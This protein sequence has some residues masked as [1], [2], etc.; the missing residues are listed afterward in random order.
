LGA[1]GSGGIF[2]PSL[3]LGAMT[4]GFLGTLVHYFQPAITAGAGAYAT[5]GMGA[6]VAA[7]THA[8]LTAMIIIFEMTGNYKIIAPLMASCVIATVLSIRLK[9]TSIY[10]EKLRRRGVDLFEPVEINVLKKLPVSQVMN[11]KPLVITEGTAFGELMDLMVNSS[12]SE[13]FVV[14]NGDQ[15]VGTISVHQMRKFVLDREYLKPLIVARDIADNT[16]PVLKSTDNLDVVMK[17]F[18]QEH[19]EELPVITGSKLVGSVKRSDVLEEYHRELMKRDLSGS[20]HGALACV[21]RTKSV[22]L[23]EGYIMAEVEAPS[24]FVGKSLR[25]LDV[26]VNYG[27]QVILIRPAKRP[28][29]EATMVPSPEYRFAHGDVI[30]VAGDQE[31][32]QALSE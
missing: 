24:H 29:N 7:T 10:T 31:E 27:V 23:G 12:K 32:V 22:D 30:L 14:R 11:R 4:G 9:A 5:V 28:E 18:A 6:V 26:R 8:P 1:G 21:R 2:A 25:D 20:F 13:F 19:I 17:L 3:F 16:Y 15:Y